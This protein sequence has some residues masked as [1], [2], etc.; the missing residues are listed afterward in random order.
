MMEY[1]EVGRGRYI[2]LRSHRTAEADEAAQVS[3]KARVAVS[4]ES[5]VAERSQR[6]QGY[7]LGKL[8]GEFRH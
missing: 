5:D 7:L 1:V 6:Q 8:A 2:T 3:K 4:S